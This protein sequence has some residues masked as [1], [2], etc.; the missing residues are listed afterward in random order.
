MNLEMDDLFQ[1]IDRFRAVVYIEATLSF[2]LGARCDDGC[3]SMHFI[4]IS[5]G[6]KTNKLSLFMLTGLYDLSQ[7]YLWLDRL[8]DGILKFMAKMN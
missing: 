8:C 6:M 2:K 7:T 5:W 4:A 1:F 3:F